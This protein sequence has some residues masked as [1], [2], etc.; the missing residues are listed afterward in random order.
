MPV[1][2]AGSTIKS[3]PHSPVFIPKSGA[4]A[5]RRCEPGVWAVAVSNCA[6]E[7]I[8]TG[9][10]LLMISLQNGGLRIQETRPARGWPRSILG[11]LGKLP[12]R[13][14]DEFVGD[15]GVEGLVAFRRLLKIDHLDI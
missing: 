5:A 11:R 7:T 15:A 13:I 10:Y 1:L 14:D 4:S 12:V 3:P 2:L 9:E 8:R 6:G